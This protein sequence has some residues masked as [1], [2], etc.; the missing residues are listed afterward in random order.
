MCQLNGANVEKQCYDKTH[1]SQAARMGNLG[2]LCPTGGCLYEVVCCVEG[3]RDTE[4]P[5]GEAEN[6]LF[7]IPQPFYQ[8]R[9]LSALCYNGEN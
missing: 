6:M 3:K 1:L 4:A 9:I 7:L 8:S 2:L 5:H